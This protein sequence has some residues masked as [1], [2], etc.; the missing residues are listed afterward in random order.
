MKAYRTLTDPEEFR[1]FRPDMN[2]KR[3]A[4]SMERLDM[5]GKDFDHTELIKCIAKL[6][7]IDSKWI[8]SG[9]GY[10]LY[11]RP[12]VIATHK[13]LGLA[14]PDSILLYVSVNGFNSIY[15]DCIPNSNK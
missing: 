13:F 2:M 12:T 10:S 3:L 5:P 8:P 11:I 7:D 15:N 1:L 9:E 6:V 14:P 4:K